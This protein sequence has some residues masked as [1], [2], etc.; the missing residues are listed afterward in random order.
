VSIEE[1]SMVSRHTRLHDEAGMSMVFVSVGFLAFFAATTLA[2][3]VGMFM[4]A[5]TQAQNSADAA[6]MSGATALIYNSWTDRSPT[7]PVVLSAINTAKANKVMGADVDVLSSDITFPL[8]S[9]GQ[10]NLVKADVFRTT[11]RLNPVDTLIG[12]MFNVPFVDIMATATAQAA[13]ADGMTCVKP[14]I[15]PDRWAENQ[16]PPWTTSSTFDRYNNQGVVIANPDTY[17]ASDGWG[18]NPLRDDRGT[19]LILRAQQ[20]NNIAP[21][22]Y[23]SWKM[24]GEIGGSFYE[25]NIANCNP[26]VIKVGYVAQQEPGA[27]EG[28]TLS[29]LQTLLARDPYASWDDYN[30]KVVSDMNPSPRIF[31][32][33]L[34]NPDEFQSGKTTGRGATLIVTNWLGFFLEDI[35]GGDVIGR[36]FPIAGVTAATGP[37]AGTPL[38][39][40]IRLVQ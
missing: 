4:T 19:R 18:K 6:A 36:V 9:F 7:G 27:M 5:R 22:M 11:A 34:Y 10:A 25:D 23:Y 20:G 28:P 8:D 15:I 26:T 31:P 1:E 35:Q 40:V 2:I 32:I 12:K 33:P 24:P 37:S 17:T 39:F 29:G 16:N 30:K 3:D 14:F 21:S 38:A 13:P